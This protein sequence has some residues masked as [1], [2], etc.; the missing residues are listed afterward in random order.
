MALKEWTKLPSRWIEQK[1][2]RELRWANGTGADNLAGLMTLLVLVHHAD[3]QGRT[4]ITYDALTHSTGL[5]RAK[6]AAGLN[7]VEGMGLISRDERR[8]GYVLRDYDPVAN[9]AK[10]PARLLYSDGRI[11]AFDDFKLRSPA[12]LHAL[13]LYFLFASRR[14]RLTNFANISFNKITEYSGVEQHSIKRAISILLHNGLLYVERQR[15]YARVGGVA[16][17]YRL[18]GLETRNHSGTQ[19]ADFEAEIVS[20]TNSAASDFTDVTL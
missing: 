3:D 17:A 14:D 4:V 7:V 2:L 8:S 11:V 16:N 1:R 6:V 10:V 12:E 13:K 5:S 9:W 20:A 15:S 19:P 18:V